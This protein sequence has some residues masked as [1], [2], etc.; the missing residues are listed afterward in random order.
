MYLGR[1]VETGSTRAVLAGPQ[2][3][4][5]KALCDVVPRRQT[6]R[7]RVPVSLLRGEADATDAASAGQGCRFRPRCRYAVEGCAEE[8]PALRP[9]E[10]EGGHEAACIRSG[11]FGLAENVRAGPE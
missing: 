1:I 5:T 8:D 6:R 3:P 7:N 9:V 4:Y 11:L 2:H 10:A